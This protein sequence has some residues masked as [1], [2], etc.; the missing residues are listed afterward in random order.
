MFRV[1]RVHPKEDR[2]IPVVVG[3]THCL[4]LKPTPDGVAPY[5]RGMFPGRECV[6]ITSMTK[7]RFNASKYRDDDRYQVTADFKAWSMGVQITLVE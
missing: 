5:G 2:R 3:R 4:I 7:E 1:D 6:T